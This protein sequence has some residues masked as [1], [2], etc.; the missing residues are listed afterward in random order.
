ME[1]PVEIANLPDECVIVAVALSLAC[2]YLAT[3]TDKDASYWGEYF[4]GKAVRIIADVRIPASTIEQ[5][6]AD[7]LTQGKRLQP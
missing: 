6:V 1:N 3:I 4:G 5:L 7:A 2:Q